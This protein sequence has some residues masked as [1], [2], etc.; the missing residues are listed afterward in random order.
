MW[1]LCEAVAA[2]LGGS[3]AGVAGRM[4]GGAV[5]RRATASPFPIRGDES[6]GNLN[7]LNFEHLWG[8]NFL[9][10]YHGTYISL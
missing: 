6:N 7:G 4:A 5:G 2:L 10:K 3:A 8:S 1:E 9:E